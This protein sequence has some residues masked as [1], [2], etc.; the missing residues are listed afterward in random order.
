MAKAKSIDPFVCDTPEVEI[1]SATSLILKQRMKTVGEGRLVSA[2]Q[3]RQR[4]EL[5]LSKSST[6]KKR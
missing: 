1:N 6:T 4:I 2:E 3:A 5:W